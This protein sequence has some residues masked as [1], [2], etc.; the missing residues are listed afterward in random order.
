MLPES[1]SSTSRRLSSVLTHTTSPSLMKSSILAAV[2]RTDPDGALYS[3]RRHSPG[4]F[5]R[6]RT[7][8][9]FTF[10]SM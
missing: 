9:V 3:R 5:G 1:R 7:T 8:G 6:P 2:H 10:F 4:S